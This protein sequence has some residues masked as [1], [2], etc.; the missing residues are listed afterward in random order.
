MEVK[1]THNDE[2]Y[3]L[4]NFEVRGDT[5]AV[6]SLRYNRNTAKGACLSARCLVVDD[7]IYIIGSRHG[8]LGLVSAIP[9]QSVD[10]IFNGEPF[11]NCELEPFYS[12]LRLMKEIREKTYGDVTKVVV[13]TK[14]SLEDDDRATLMSVLNQRE[15]IAVDLDFNPGVLERITQSEKYRRKAVWENRGADSFWEV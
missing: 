3:S 5:P 8:S 11:D 6:I 10:A 9:P 12:E 13:S 4:S 7:A 1:G 15:F 14:P 2:V